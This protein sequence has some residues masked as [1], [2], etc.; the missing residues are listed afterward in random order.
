MRVMLAEQARRGHRLDGPGRHDHRPLGRTRFL[1]RGILPGWS[2][3][4]G[5]PTTPAQLCGGLS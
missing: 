5:A 3:L 2:P 1:L 4:P